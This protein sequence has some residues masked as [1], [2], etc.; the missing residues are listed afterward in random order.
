MD[1]ANRHVSLAVQSQM[2]LSDGHQIAGGW[3]RLQDPLLIIT[4]FNP[5]SA[6]D[7]N[8]RPDAA[9]ITSISMTVSVNCCSSQRLIAAAGDISMLSL[10]AC[11]RLK[12]PPSSVAIPLSWEQ[13]Q[14][15]CVVSVSMLVPCGQTW[16]VSCSKS[17]RNE[18]SAKFGSYELVLE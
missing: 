6:I 7:K 11:G 4:I 16:P 12:P 3:D 15:L 1:F 9:G 18:L 10:M 14:L 13:N 17:V 8:P 5:Q 2:S